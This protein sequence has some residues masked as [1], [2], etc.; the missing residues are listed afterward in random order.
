MKLS[1]FGS[2]KDGEWKGK[3]MEGNKKERKKPHHFM[4]RANSSFSSKSRKSFMSS[5]LHWRTELQPHQLA[6]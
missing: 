2:F 5:N 6:I 1:I 4:F 3:R